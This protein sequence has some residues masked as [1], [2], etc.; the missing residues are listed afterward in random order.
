M[1]DHNRVTLHVIVCVYMD[2]FWINNSSLFTQYFQI[3]GKV[4]FFLVVPSLGGH[5]SVR[6]KCFFHHDSIRF[7]WTWGYTV[8]IDSSIWI[9]FM[10]HLNA[11]S[12]S[13]H[14][15]R[16]YFLFYFM[17]ILW[18]FYI[19]RRLIACLMKVN[20]SWTRAYNSFQSMRMHCHSSNVSE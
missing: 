13:N 3:F 6:R 15:G 18:E 1:F 10:S 20:V 9:Q 5:I 16:S 2:V 17:I 14:L 19:Y 7:I 8:G 4:I 11:C 12:V